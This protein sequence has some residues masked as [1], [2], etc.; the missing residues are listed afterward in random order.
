MAVIGID[1][2]TTYC[3]AGV[4]VDGKPQPI[5][6]EGEPTLPSVVGLQKNGKIAVGKVAKRNQAKSP[7]N[8]VVEV[9][10]KMGAMETLP[11]RTERPV[12]VML[13]E[14]PFLP[15]EISAMI[16]RKIKECVEAELGEE[17]TGAVITCPAYFRDPQR[18]ATKEAG[19]IAGLNVLK[20]VNEPTAAAYAYGVNLDTH[21]RREAV[22]RLR[23]G[24]RHV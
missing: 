16:L 23:S 21:P 4:C 19:Q 18:A 6:L 17:V 15:Q 10:R 9:K 11:D 8:T 5:P 24:R 14:K 3:A 12:K 22:H 2:G 7:Q 20:I 1:L 13:G